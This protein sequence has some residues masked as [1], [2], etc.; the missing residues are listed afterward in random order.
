MLV[1]PAVAAPP[2]WQPAACPIPTRW[3]KEV[4]PDKVLPEY[5]R[6]QMARADWLSL[7]GLWQ[8]ATAPADAPAP[9]GEDL[10]GRILVPFPIESALSGVGQALAPRDRLWYR[11][12]FEVPKAWADRRVLLNFGAVDWEAV[13][14]VNGNRV[15][16]H[17]GGYDAFSFDI[18]DSLNRSAIRQE[19]LVGVLDP[20][21]QGEQP[22]GRQ[23]LQP[24]AGSFSASSG[25]WQTVW[26]EPV[27]AARITGLAMTPDVAGQG[28]RL[29]VLVSEGASGTEVTAVVRAGDADVANAAGPAGQEFRVPVP[30]ARLWTPDNPFLYTLRVSL[31]RGDKP[32]DA[33]DSYFGMRKV[34]VASDGRVRR[35]LLNGAPVFQVGV[36]ARGYWPDGLYAAPTDAALKFDLEK[37]KNLGF[38]MIRMGAKVEADRW[39]YWADKLGLLVWQDMPAGENRTPA[40]QAQFEAELGRMVAGRGNHPSIVA[41]VLFDEGTG[42]FDAPRLVARVKTIDPTRLVDAASGWRDEGA[43]DLVDSHHYPTP[44][45]LPPDI[46]R[47]S[48]LG[49]FGGLLLAVPGHTWRA[50]PGAGSGA[51]ADT[52][53]APYEKLLATSWKLWDYPGLSAA[54]YTELYDVESEYIGLMTYDREVVKGDAGRITAANRGAT[55]AARP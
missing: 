7:N 54:V 25:I 45:A 53:T 39:Y 1:M 52:L 49:G 50:V 12:T 15:G 6:P 37:A 11:R 23:A 40:G 41:W 35:I 34:E 3:F 51:P 2:A 14:Y 38:N 19:I 8:F 24:Q 36:L 47:A 9:V 44:E 26:L 18:T 29:K 27:P 16:A 42:Q 31:G 20:T 55:T 4:A 13:V 46:R 17:R 10:P 32:T 30:T 28:L 43:G 48:V 33:V 5:P 21:D 22:R